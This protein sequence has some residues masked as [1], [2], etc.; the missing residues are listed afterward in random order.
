MTD[1]K[2]TKPKVAFN[3]DVKV[4]VWV[5]NPGPIAEVAIRNAAPNRTDKLLFFFSVNIPYPLR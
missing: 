2:I 1:V 5:K 3:E 4:A